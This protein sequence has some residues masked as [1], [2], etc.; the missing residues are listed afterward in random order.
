MNQTRTLHP[1]AW[2]GIGCAVLVVVGAVAV[3][4]LGLFAKNKISDFA[5]A[6]ENNP[7]GTAAR[8]YA[9][10]HPDIEFV[11]ADE[12]TERITF[13]NKET[14]E[15]L[16]V[17][18]ADLKEGRLVLEDGE[19][20]QTRLEGS[21]GSGVSVTT[22]EGTTRFGAGGD[23]DIPS[24]VP[25]VDGVELS[26]AYSSVTGGSAAGMIQATGIP[27][28]QIFEGYRE[29]LSAEGWEIA[30]EQSVGGV[31]RIFEARLADGDRQIT[32]TWTEGN[33]A[34]ALTYRG[35]AE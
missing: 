19:G 11:A 21:E 13:R 28:E 25:R 2:V 1:L 17:D 5:D 23:E 35:D 30:S 15:E 16:T 4:A 10:V 26:S 29:R 24:W 7:V 31:A 33:D 3:F 12:E 20:R 9:A 32:V 6:V 34:V 22:D 8:A 27:N 14:G 18:Y